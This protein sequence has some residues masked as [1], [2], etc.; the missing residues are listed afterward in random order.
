MNITTGYTG[1]TFSIK[2]E[3]K[4]GEIKLYVT[5]GTKQRNVG[6]MISRG[7][8]SLFITALEDIINSQDKK[9]VE[10]IREDVPWLPNEKD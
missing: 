9:A 3:E 8:A 6:N 1:K 10:P 4:N 5:R 7:M 2:T